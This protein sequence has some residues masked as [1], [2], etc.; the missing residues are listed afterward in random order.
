MFILLQYIKFDLILSAKKASRL[1]AK[2]TLR[3]G[4]GKIKVIVSV[5][6]LDSDCTLS[7]ISDTH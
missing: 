5:F 7:I 6:N 2:L 3:Y 4:I 1:V